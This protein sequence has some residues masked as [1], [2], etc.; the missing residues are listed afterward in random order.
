MWTLRQYALP[1]ISPLADSFWYISTPS[2]SN[3]KINSLLQTSFFR[4]LQQCLKKKFSC[5]D[6]CDNVILLDWY[7][8]RWQG[9]RLSNV[10]FSRLYARHLQPHTRPV[11]VEKT[12]WDRLLDA[13]SSWAYR[14]GLALTP[15]TFMGLM[16]T[17]TV[18][19]EVEVLNTADSALGDVDL[20][21]LQYFTAD[22]T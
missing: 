6:H 18:Q 15:K 8:G 10:V 16:K 5:F 9:H 19:E 2:C 22:T 4:L 13:L 20:L 17:V 12:A 3:P 1:L 11:G 21:Y 7:L 14:R